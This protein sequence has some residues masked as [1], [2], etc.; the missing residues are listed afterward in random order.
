MAFPWLCY[1]VAVAIPWLSCAQGA[2]QGAVKAC[3]GV[4]LPCGVRP[5]PWL[6]ACRQCAA[7]V[8]S[9]CHR[10]RR[11]CSRMLLS[12]FGLSPRNITSPCLTCAWRSTTTIFRS[13]TTMSPCTVCHHVAC[14]AAI[15]RLPCLAVHLHLPLS[16]SVLCCARA[17]SAVCCLH[18]TPLSVKMCA[19]RT[20]RKKSERMTGMQHLAPLIHQ[21]YV[22]VL[23][24]CAMVSLLGKM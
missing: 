5:G 18:A 16:A 6:A 8:Y 1:S 4:A 7:A 14:Q 20:R 12:H 9:C 23:C 13:T 19:T 11:D 24:P 22:H 3:L 10:L 21:L 17:P 15:C 2:S